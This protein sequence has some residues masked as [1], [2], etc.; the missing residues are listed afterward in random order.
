[1]STRRSWARGSWL[2]PAEG[3]TGPSRDT[4]RILCY[5]DT[6]GRLLPL[7]SFVV[8]PAR[9]RHSNMWSGGL[10]YSALG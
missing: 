8:R 9:G 5:H 10:T 4:P 1:M 6:A 2:V 7:R 3:P